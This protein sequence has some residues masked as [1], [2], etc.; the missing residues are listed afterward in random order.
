MGEVS[1]IPLGVDFPSALV[2]GLLARM[3]GQPPEAMARVQLFL[4]TA[5]MRRRVVEILTASGARLLP[6]IHLLGD[7]AALVPDLP[8][9]VPPLRL[10]L[11]LARLITALLNAQPDLA[12][13]AATFDLAESLATLLGEMG[14]E[15]V[16]PE[17]IGALDVSHHS[18][19]WARTQAFLAIVAPIFAGQPDGDRRARLAVE[20]LAA[21]WQTRPPEGPVIVAGSTGSRGT[22]ALFMRAVAALPQGALVLPGFDRDLPL[23]VWEAL[24]DALT[25]EDHPQYRFHRLLR[26]LDLGPGDVT[27]WTDDIPVAP[28]RNR[29]VSL[30]LRPA[31]VTDQ[32]L[33]EGRDLG[34]LRAAGQGLTLIEAPR[35]RIEAQAIALILR[36]AAEDGRRAALISPDRGLTRMVAAALDRWGIVP[37]D[38]AGEPLQQTAAGRL[39]RLIGHLPGRRLTPETL[40]TLLKHPLTATGADRGNHLRWTRDL[41]LHLRRN[42]PPF[43]VAADLAAWAATRPADGV[44]DWAEW[45]GATLDGLE[46]IGTRSLSAHLEHHLRVAERLA[47]GPGATGSGALWSAAAGE[48]A[49]ALVSDLRAEAEHGGD[50]SPADY[51]EL[52][53]SVLSRGEVRETV[54]AHPGIMIWGTLEARVQG[55]DLVVLGGL[56]DGTWPSLPDP[57]PWLNRQMR[58]AAGLLLPERQIGLSAHDYQQAVAMPEVVLSRAV[59]DAEA[60]T[61]PSRWLNRLQ[62]L[63][64]GLPAQSGPEALEE[65]RA[66]GRRWLTRAVQL[67][68]PEGIQPLARRPAPRPPVE[69]R[70][71]QLPVTGIRTLI[72]DPYAVYASTILRLKPLAPLRQTPDARLRGSVLHRVLETFVREGGP[73]EHARLMTVAARILAEDV[74]WPAARALWLARMERAADF[75]LDLEAGSE[76][77]PVWLEESGGV[78]VDPLDFR[79]T[80]RPDRIDRL[81]DGTLHIVDY[82]TGIP[83]TPKQQK[84]FEKQLLLEAAMAERGGFRALGPTPVSRVSYIGL[85][86]TPKVEATDITEELLGEV[87]EQLHALIGRYGLREQGYAARRAVFEDRMAGDYDHL[88][89]YG[90]WEMQDPSHPEDVG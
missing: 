56:N 77:E 90:E 65:M 5:R 33:S 89:R 73:P 71:R 17:A 31:P 76:A 22:T 40:L 2:R 57:D 74:P 23:P 62:N 10:R 87:W 29:L 24:S 81:P 25:A 79:L 88:A 3:E 43:P 60:E 59:R 86:L 9:A 45:V 54:T 83:P 52:F 12:P 84:A 70:P 72:R 16:P 18:A 1:A 67:E 53:D 41:E 20:A 46:G 8:A 78:R 47:A 48:A 11:E 82:K 35:P 6:R 85:G 51:A 38:S 15:D 61:V 30:S 26:D 27:D 63:M 64:A 75:F 14:Q 69:V 68:A 4:N 21:R 66:R 36:K 42:G 19:H 32:W 58:L 37:D 55:A 80:A 28:A 39:L 34:C 50:M 13:R 44:A 49:C 7:V